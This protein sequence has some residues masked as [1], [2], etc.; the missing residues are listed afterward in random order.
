[1]K[2]QFIDIGTKYNSH[3]LFKRDIHGQVIYWSA[4]VDIENNRIGFWHGQAKGNFINDEPKSYTEP[5][6]GVNIGKSNET[7]NIEQCLKQLE[8]EYKNHIK[9][10]YKEYNVNADLNDSADWLDDW[11]DLYVDK[12][13]TDI[14]GLA[15]PM[16][17]QKFELNK[18]HYPAYGQ[19][20]YNGVRCINFINKFNTSL[21]NDTPIK[22]LSKEGV[23]YDVEHLNTVSH[24]I[25]KTFE[26]IGIKDPILD[27][28]LYIPYTPVTTIGGSARNSS[29]PYNKK[30]QYVIFDLSI[31]NF[32]Q[33]DRLGF[34]KEVQR[35]LTTDF[36]SNK[37]ITPSVYFSSYRIINNDEEAVAYCDECLANGYEGAVLREMEPE[38]AFG[39]RPM[40]MRK[41]KHFQDAEFE[42][43][44]I[45]EYGTRG[46]NVGSGCKVICRNDTTDGTFEV[47]PIG[48]TE[49]RLSLVDD[50]DKLIGKMATVKFY[51]RTINNLPFHA[52]I[53]AINRD[54]EQE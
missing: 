24:L 48:T 18:V 10:G 16:K 52:N 42:I 8:S 26:S 27:G 53:T 41:L 46:Q 50:K 15:K 35:Q 21:F 32:S 37:F 19:P 54:Y 23:E 22:L 45:I 20:K 13:N 14:N 1:M 7:S 39:Q 43:L 11:L 36:H 4:A 5:I 25:L 30:L 31:E 47:T 3:Y 9:K 28:E 6:E 12:T 49:Y 33:R 17:C 29:N 44:D 2:K 40:F 38:Y 34:I 51:E